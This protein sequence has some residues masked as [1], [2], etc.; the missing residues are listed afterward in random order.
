MPATS[1]AQLSP[2]GN[3]LAFLREFHGKAT[4]HFIDLAT[5]KLSRLDLGEA[6]LANGAV[7]SVGG[8]Q[9]IGH[10]R[11][12]VTTIVWDNTL[13]GVTATN[14]DGA[15]NMPIS[16]FEDSK[17]RVQRGALPLRHLA[18]RGDRLAGFL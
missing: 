9:W 12:V 5:R 7:K 16:G 6:E 14:W 1:R 10:E 11:L 13:Y 2:D 4:L 17:L 8:Y 15:Q 3:R 18:L